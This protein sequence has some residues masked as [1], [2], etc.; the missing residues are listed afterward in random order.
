MHYLKRT[1]AAFAVAIGV[2]SWV[3]QAAAQDQKPSVA[4]L[5]PVETNNASNVKKTSKTLVWGKMQEL[6]LKSKKYRVV[7]RSRVEQLLK[8][9]SFTT[10]S[11]MVDNDKVKALGKML[12]ADCVCVLAMQKD[13]S[14]INLE[15]TLM[16]VQTGEIF[17]SGSDL[18][19]GDTDAQILK[20]LQKVAN[21]I[22]DVEDPGD[23]IVRLQ[24]MMAAYNKAVLSPHTDPSELA[25]AGAKM[26][27]NRLMRYFDYQKDKEGAVSCTSRDIDSYMRRKKE[28]YS[29]KDQPFEWYVLT[30][31]IK[32]DELAAYS[33]WMYLKGDEDGRALNHYEIGVKAGGKI[34]TVDFVP[35]KRSFWDKVGTTL[36]EADSRLN[37]ASS[38]KGNKGDGELTKTVQALDGNVVTEVGELAESEVVLRLIADAHNRDIAVQVTLHGDE[39]A[40]VELEERQKRAI[41]QTIE[42]HNAFGVLRR[43]GVEIQK[44]YRI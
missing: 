28:S 39:Q 26:E 30:A 31:E 37:R 29:R 36:K 27:V 4:V 38:R 8:E 9:R 16:E 32:G 34:A 42:L 20:G 6:I 18:I 15:G 11:G 19:Q 2:F 33:K 41:A 35:K 7:D 43:G 17:G 25:I 3:P 40:T 1:L 21:A 24:A 10:E 23:R 44:N 5:E 13:G 22:L 12:A 14:Y